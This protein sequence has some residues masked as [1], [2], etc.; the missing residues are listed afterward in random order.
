MRSLFLSL[1]IIGLS[2]VSTAP[3]IAEN[4]M[5]SHNLT[6]NTTYLITGTDQTAVMPVVRYYS[7]YG[8]P[9]WYGYPWYRPYY[10][11]P[12]R[13]YPYRTYVVPGPVYSYDY[14]TPYDY[15][16]SGP[17]VAFRFGF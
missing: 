13:P 11:Y 2:L 6:T 5:Q 1:M 8:G 9:R 4:D 16:Y 7:Y 3:A 10:G 17:R 14:Y 12:V 15:Y